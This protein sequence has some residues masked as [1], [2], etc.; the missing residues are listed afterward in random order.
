M[1][2]DVPAAGERLR[3]LAWVGADLW[4]SSA[5]ALVRLDPETGRVLERLTVPG[6]AS[7]C[8]LAAD[9][10]RRLWCVDGASRSVRVFATSGGVGGEEQRQGLRRAAGPA[11]PTEIGRAER[12][13][14]FRSR[15]R[16]V[17]A[18]RMFQRVLVPID[19]SPSSQRG[20]AVA[21]RLQDRFGSEV[22]LVHVTED[23]AGAGCPA[24]SGAGGLRANR[25]GRARRGRSLRRER[26]PGT[27]GLDRGPRFWG[28]RPRSHDRRGRPGAPRHAGRARR[29]AGAG[30]APAERGRADR[31]ERPRRGGGARVA[32]GGSA[33][34]RPGR[35]IG[36]RSPIERTGKDLL[37]TWVAARYTGRGGGGTVSRASRHKGVHVAPYPRT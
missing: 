34:M 8:D 23:L 16:E 25:G 31:A 13:S 9:S 12:R 19:R 29:E 22:H 17:S 5:G 10:G 11:P 26:P 2:D 32:G 15:P 4:S 35:A 24:A 7:I 37:A 18:G 14:P 28:D 20:L 3:G 6:A 33:R 27:I 30:H 1:I 36:A 21:L